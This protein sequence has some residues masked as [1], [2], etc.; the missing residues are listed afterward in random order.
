MAYVEDITEALIRTLAY[1]SGL[2]VQKLAGHAANLEFW[3][4][5]VKHAIDV[6]DGYGERFRRLKEGQRIHAEENGLTFDSAKFGKPIR[7][8]IS[9]HDLNE[10]RRRLIDSVYGVLS[11]FYRERLVSESQLENY[12]ANFDLD[13][14]AL[15]RQK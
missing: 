3:M 2:P 10:L 1:T 5:E 14:R 8:G 7:P 12:G 15:T 13:L 4:G 9:D 11:R 6:I